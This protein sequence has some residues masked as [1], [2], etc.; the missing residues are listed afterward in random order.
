MN[1]EKLARKLV[2]SSF[3]ERKNLLAENSALADV[4]LAQAL[5]NLCY[6]VWASEP[7]KVSGIVS[8][9]IL[10]SEQ[11]GEKEIEGVL[12]WARGIKNLINGKLEKCLWRLDRSEK[13]FKSLGKKHAAA[14]TQISKLYALALLG[15]YDEAV[16]CGLTAREVFLA[17]NDI[18]SV[19]KIEHNIGN[20]FWRRDLYAEAEPFLTS[21]FEHFSAINDQRQ[22]A[23]VENTQAFVKSLQND[24]STAEKIYE[25]AIRRAE[26]NSLTVTQAE[27]EI[28]LSNLYLFQGRPDLALKFMERARCKY[29]E[30]Q[31]PVQTAVC[32]L[33]L[34]D[35][36]LELNLLQEAAKL[37]ES[38][39]EKFSAAKMQAELA[40]CSMGFARTL[41]LSGE[42]ERA[43]HQIKQAEKLFRSEGN[44]IGVASARIFQAQLF[45]LEKSF[46]A[47]KNLAE[48]A[49]QVFNEGKSQR[50]KLFACWL[51][52][53]IALAENQPEKAI[54]IFEKTL[55]ATEK[56]SSSI[57]NLCLNALG[58][59]ALK[60]QNPTKAEAFFKNAI[61][62][63]ENIR[64]TLEAEELRLAFLSNKISPYLEI[65]K[66]KLAEKDFPTALCWL[67]RSRSRSLLDSI[68]VPASLKNNQQDNYPLLKKAEKLRRELN[69]F[70][71]RLNRAST[72]G[73]EM[74]QKD[75][76]LK[77]QIFERE[78]KLLEL[79]RRLPHNLGY[80]FEFELETLQQLLGEKILVEYA[81]LDGQISAFVVDK[82][83]IRFCEHLA[84]E[85]LVNEEIEQLLFQ[86]KTGRI[87]EKMRKANQKL[88]FARFFQH[89]KKLYDL[90]IRPLKNFLQKTEIV[91]VPMGR[92]HYL[93]FHT[94]FDGTKFLIEKTTVSYA[95]SA[96]VLINCLR[97]PGKNYNSA[98]LAAFADETIP[99]AES[100]VEKISGFLPNS[101]KLKGEKATLRNIQKFAKSFNLLHLACHAKFRS[102]N[103]LFSALRLADENLLVR[104]ARKIALEDKLVVLS[105]C[106]T[107]LNKIE[108]GEEILG[109]ARGF[110]SA[111][112]K[113]L[114]LSFW[115]VNDDS[116]QDLMIDFYL[117]IKRGK[118]PAEALRIAQNN[119]LRTEKHPYFWAPFFLIGG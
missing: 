24:F 114:I 83:E 28:G 40:R 118:S 53:E 78:K 29:E 108:S 97:K 111:G 32:E 90:L 51:L 69:W 105:A 99:K 84:D 117:E 26:K 119:G 98:L 42:T 12:E 61:E 85:A 80:R 22:M 110:L 58:K 20:L 86:I 45:F 38:S 19:G 89:S 50:N 72:S 13:I 102:D 66:I 91:I 112:A 36:Y 75:N 46:T 76:L 73:L 67:E 7:Q 49:F 9:L 92:M 23:M 17:E 94:L 63:I 16:R 52:G 88:A 104:D 18:Y 109:L 33:E 65:A 62:I 100:E 1:P 10:L 15:R 113:S 34:A 44:S 31:M 77:E 95:P 27:I 6:E 116:T 47:A 115:T 55:A 39:G 25:R 74:R 87:V 14:K 106:E 54:T 8:A 82:E 4:R 3:V 70:Y 11:T 79:E 101:V 41:L 60:K 48:N 5:Q 103:P 68:T 59:I 35:I 64:S 56:T 81:I 2:E 107:G 93:P 96:S 71:S 30:L 21:A 43:Y 57:K 37:F